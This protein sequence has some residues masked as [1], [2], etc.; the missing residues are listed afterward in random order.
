MAMKLFKRKSQ[1][2]GKKNKASQCSPN[3][4]VL[5]SLEPRL[6][7]SGE[8]AY[9]AT[10]AINDLTVQMQDAAGAQIIQIVNNADASVVASRALSETSGVVI[11]GSTEN[12]SITVDLGSFGNSAI[13]ITVNDSSS[14][15]NDTLKITGKDV[16][17]NIQNGQTGSAEQVLFSGIEKLVGSEKDDTFIFFSDWGTLSISDPGGTD[18]VD[19]SGVTADLTFTI[20]TDGTV[21]ATDGLNTLNITGGMDK[22]SGGQGNNTFAFQNGASFAGEIDGGQGVTNTLDYSAYT[23]G[24]TVNLKDKTAAGAGS[25]NNI[26]NVIGG[27]GD[28]IITGGVGDNTLSGGGGSDTYKLSNDWWTDTVIDSGAGG[29]DTLDFS[30]VVENDATKELVFTFHDDGT[31]TVTDH[32]NSL[33]PTVGIEKIIGGELDNRF[34]FENAASFAGIIQGGS[35][36]KNILDYSAYKTPVLVDLSTGMAKVG[37]FIG[38]AD[39]V[40]LTVNTPLAYLNNGSGVEKASITTDT[41]ISALNNG[42]GIGLVE[43][44]D[45]RITLEDGRDVDID[46]D[47]VLTVQDLLDKINSADEALLAGLNSLS[48]GIDVASY[49]GVI[50]SLTVSNLN[51]STAATDLGLAG[52]IAGS[53]IYGKPFIDDLLITLRDGSAVSVKIGDAVTVGDVIAAINAADS[54]LTASINTAANGIVITDSTDTGSDM[55]VASL[56]GC[57]AAANLG[58]AGIGT[59]GSLSGTAVMS[60]IVTMTF[61][62]ISDVT[63]GSGGDL[64]TG[65]DQVNNLVGGEGADTYRFKG[66][67]GGDTLIDYGF[68]GVDVLDF[69][70][71]SSNLIF[72][73][74]RDGKVSVS[75]GNTIAKDSTTGVLSVSNG[76]NSLLNAEMLEKIIGGS[77]NNRFVFEDGAIFDGA[78]DGGAGG[79]NTLDY[80]DY[81]SAV[82]VDLGAGKATGTLG[83]S[84]FK[85]VIGGSGND[86]IVGD[87]QTN[88]LSGGAG[89]D[90]LA[91][92]GQNDILTGGAGDDIYVIV[93]GTQSIVESADEGF[94][95]L[96]YNNYAVSGVGII[97]DLQNGLAP[98]TTGVSNIENVLGTSEDDTFTGTD[99]DD[100]FYFVNDWGVDTVDDY[101]LGPGEEPTID[102]DT[103][104]FSAVTK[105][106]TFTFTSGSVSVSQGEST[107]TGTRIESVV[108]GSSDDLF[109]FN[110]GWGHYTIISGGT[111][112]EDILD[113]SRISA[114]LTFTLRNDGKVSVSDG[115]NTLGASAGIENI[116]GGSGINTFIFEDQGGLEGYIEGAGTNILDYSAYTTTVFLDLSTMDVLYEGLVNG[117]WTQSYGVAYVTGLKGAN[118]ITGIIGGSSA[119]D[120]LIGPEQNSAWTIDGADSGTL[121]T[122]TKSFTFSGIE[123]ITGAIDYNDS[124][125]VTATGSLSGLLSGNPYGYVSSA[126]HLEIPMN[127]SGVA[128]G[129]DTLTLTGGTY[130]NVAFTAMSDDAGVIA[131]DTDKLRF[132]G[133]E[134][135]VDNSAA[136]DRTFTYAADS[137]ARVTL[138]GGVG[139]GQSWGMKVDGVSY[140]YTAGENDGLEDVV[141]GL[142]ANIAAGGYLTIVQDLSILITNPGGS[143]PTVV[144]ETSTPGEVKE[145]PV[146]GFSSVESPITRDISLRI[147][148]DSSLHITGERGEFT[149]YTFNQPSGHVYVNTGMGNDTITVGQ[150]PATATLEIDGGSGN[151]KIVYEVQGG[152][153]AKTITF[154]TGDI[155]LNNN[156]VLTYSNVESAK[157]LVIKAT[158][159]ND[160]V[161]LYEGGIGYAVSGS[162]APITFEK[163]IQSLTIDLGEGY[164]DSFESYVGTSEKF[165]PA[166]KIMADDTSYDSDYLNLG[167]GNYSMVTFG[168][169]FESVNW[170][171]HVDNFVFDARPSIANRVH[172]FDYN[173]KITI[174]DETDIGTTYTYINAPTGSLTINTGY[175]APAT[176]EY[177]HVGQDPDGNVWGMGT[178][179]GDLIINAGSLNKN[180]DGGDTVTIYSDLTLSGHKLDVTADN[181]NVYTG[182]TV[183]TSS[184]TG[185]AGDINLT[186]LHINIGTGAKLLA[187]TKVAGVTDIAT[188]G[189]ITIKA[190][191][192][193]ALV[194]PLVDVDVS[195]VD[196]TIA[197]GAVISGRDVT[198]LASSDNRRLYA[199]D[200]TMTG[201]A[202]NTIGGIFEMLTTI[203][204]GCLGGDGRCFHRH[205]RR[206]SDLCPGLQGRCERLRRCQGYTLPGVWGFTLNRGCRDKC[207]SECRRRDHHYR[208][209]RVQDTHGPY[210]E[211][212]R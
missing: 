187:E 145:L 212:R 134:S 207:R 158:A 12:D 93:N 211:R 9:Q 146:T 43:G 50:G 4:A 74:H 162:F 42:S 70:A 185:Y 183:S 97:V 60:P 81:T 139:P 38:T 95:T 169:E 86:I 136:T 76:T 130:S 85:N 186:G 41:L 168:G 164:Y 123:N 120:I 100:T 106:M 14:A 159:G 205:R 176:T 90:I 65:S 188:S 48:N 23:T 29:I 193:S 96:A 20:K 148:K 122:S 47:G 175:N 203:G 11:T 189:D 92:G 127:P 44:N 115:T 83:I 163:A 199:E 198:I 79:T 10:A 62:D 30:A 141:A 33:T 31:I 32:T 78:L 195:N 104:D 69:S 72:I 53:T 1:K 170:T 24:I 35:A 98:G 194:T 131:R 84:Q 25:I 3:R 201:T 160:T 103:L 150:F 156:V 128:E 45:L 2:K 152:T 138:G 184:S 61:T 124:F 174:V 154:G 109:I 182:V 19:F 54:R 114:N 7:L 73:F 56:L 102:N 121:T 16:T 67:W 105:A 155:K 15:D 137:T 28:D 142:A 58:I 46:L 149:P 77:G 108:G 75:D 144:A 64:L 71:V 196:V 190:M 49:T 117:V 57:T 34:V 153:S 202:L 204:G 66:A 125:T 52:T 181:I 177:V 63:G 178:F 87:G 68:E 208:E 80:S 151:D 37:G 26:Q 107:A 147:S 171:G 167:S 200:G 99:S 165:A 191:D 27:S 8:L 39:M 180:L 36:G 94:D 129:T 21:S 173:G 143:I 82:A 110:D 116:I 111:I 40:G 140:S 197:S 17:W 59:G 132:A 206:F 166:L 118:N 18:T 6:L 135:V 5:E 88:E 51:G 119:N 91:G 89:N 161:Q 55:Q 126:M 179:Y 22:L 112:D 209:C 172:V 113:F 101:I 13:P 157:N 210:D 192:E 133:F